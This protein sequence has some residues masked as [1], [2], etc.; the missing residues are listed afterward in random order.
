MRK[1]R[2]NN[3]K[4]IQIAVSATFSTKLVPTDIELGTTIE[5]PSP[6]LAEPGEG[7]AEASDQISE[8]PPS[9]EQDES[10]AEAN[11]G[12]HERVRDIRDST[13]RTLEL[14][15]RLDDLLARPIRWFQRDPVEKGT[16]VK[17]EPDCE[18]H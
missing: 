11:D 5:M 3:D 15:K 12:I 6:P 4:Q 17:S 9:A 7:P 16:A 1:D 2:T 18:E 8:S 13:V 10:S 14:S